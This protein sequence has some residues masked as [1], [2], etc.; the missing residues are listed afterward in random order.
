VARRVF[1]DGRKYQDPTYVAGQQTY[2]YWDGDVLTLKT[3][4]FNSGVVGNGRGW[5]EPTT[6]LTETFKLQNNGQRLIWTYTYDDPAV[7]LKPHTFDITFERLP[8]SQYIF[9]TFCDSKAWFEDQA[10]Q[11]AAGRGGAAAAPAGRGA[12]A[13]PAAPAAP[14]AGR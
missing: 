14:A 7:Y 8:N 3:K 2:G 9:E 10:K 6:E 1:L 5:T 4:G 12:G 11:A 13:G